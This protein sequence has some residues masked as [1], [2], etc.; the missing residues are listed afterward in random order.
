MT[1]YNGTS[2][3]AGQISAALS[4]TAMVFQDSDPA[5][6]A[7][8]MTASTQ[9]YAAGARNRATYTNFF[10][11]PCAE[12]VDSTNVVS[13]PQAK[14]KPADELFSGAMLGTFNSTSYYDD[15]TWAAAWLNMATG[16]SAYLSDAYRYDL[17][18]HHPTQP[19]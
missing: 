7:Q 11:Y 19:F 18:Q 4:S 9:I 2:D 17:S 12:D 1:T 5:Y 8:L 14:C 15:L 3:V 13:T 6:Y 10:N 16:D